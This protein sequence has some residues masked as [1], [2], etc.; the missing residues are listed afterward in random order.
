MSIYDTLNN[1]QREAVFCTEGPLLMLAG[2]GSGKTRSL[3][4]RIA[5]LIEEKGVAPWNILAITFTNKAA[6]EMRERVD[7]L[8]GYGSE[9]IWISTFHA[10]CSR[11]LRRHIDLLGYDRNFTI[12]DA[13]DQKSLMKE[14]LKE[15]KI[16]TKQFP[17]RS[18]MSEISSAKNEYKS[19][20]DYRNEYGSNFRNQR[21]ADIYEHYQKRLKENN[22]LDFDDLLVKMVD[23]FQTN[24][25]VLEHYQD[26]FQYIMVDEYQ[27]TNTVQFL[28]VSLLAKKY[29]N[30]CVVGDDDQSIYKFR[31]ANIYNILNFEKV[32]P[33]AQVI[34]LEQN[35]RS[36]QNI[37]NAANG[38][39]ANNKGRKEKKLW[40]ENQKGELV[41]FKQYDT[42]YD[43]ADGV[44]SRINFLAM[45]G[46]QYKDMAI[47]Y[48]TNAQSRIFEEKL[49]QK[50]I[51]YAIVRGISFYDR[52]EIKD[53]MSYLKVV[54][55]GMDD[56][57]VKRIINVPKRGI[58]QTTI[59]RLQEFA[60][61]NQMSFLD[62]VFNADE[63]PEVT[64]ALAKLHKF[65][66][67]I[68]EFREYASEHEIS[69][70]LE[71][72]LDVT[73]YR[74]ELEA[75]G[76]DESISRLEDIEEL[77]NDIAYYEEEEENPNLRDFL[78]EKDMYTLN[79]GIDNLEDENNKV[80]LMTLHNAKGLEF[81]NVFL[82][83][84]EEGVFPG[85]GAMM[86][87]DESEI[88]E[89][90]RLCYVGITRAKERLFLSAAKRR[91]LRGQTQYNRRSRFIDEIPGQYLD[92]EQRVSEQRVVKN[93]E[94][95]AKYQYGAKAGKPYNLSD[96]K[97]KPVGELDYQVG[98]RVKHIKFGVGTVQEITK[99]G[100]DFE[101]AVEFDRVGRK[102]M[103]A[104]FAKLKKVK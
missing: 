61:L 14:V 4:H 104:S 82:G 28:L 19:P 37:L 3:T 96:F 33:D 46:V 53:L 92:T 98:D 22:A 20:L 12:Y 76:T 54:D 15:M 25:D 71:H 60:I 34:R 38:V 45:R 87:G 17:E 24:P 78:A 10:T 49:K 90:R 91:M 66:D 36:T 42:E 9:D 57:S 65:A 103:F 86:S 99:G 35:Y 40:T 6:Q 1:A 16:D 88:E 93:T 73:Q 52:K 31:G 70:L 69:E 80:L 39:I 7:A 51:P 11:I 32:F 5:Y 68:E 59:N 26:R 74:A 55:S 101:V 30:L 83:G 44:V 100:R 56:L 79:A 81:N 47:L 41:H 64:R 97:V 72:I 85:F 21:I 77:F 8:V 75:E 27:D 89:E 13:S 2:A 50:N 67:M 23:L 48:R 62:A 29:R 43:E 63:I 18:V 58:G 95:P 94:R 102:K 84:M